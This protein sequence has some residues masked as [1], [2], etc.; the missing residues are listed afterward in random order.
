MVES[1]Y[2]VYCSKNAKLAFM[3]H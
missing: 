1:V 2:F 3:H